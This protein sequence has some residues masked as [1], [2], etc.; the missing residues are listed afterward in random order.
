MRKETVEPRPLARVGLAGDP[1]RTAVGLQLQQLWK[2]VLGIDAVPPDADFFALGADSI[3]AMELATEMEKLFGRA[4]S[5]PELLEAATLDGMTRL[6]ES[7]ARERPI[8]LLVPLNK[9]GRRNPL[10][11]VHGLG[12]GVVQMRELAR[13]LD[14]DR[15]FYAFQARGLDGVARPLYRVEA[16]A[17]S[18]LDRMRQVRPA[19]P[20]LV[21]GYSMGG[22]VAYEMAR[23]LVAAGES[24]AALI[25][26]DAAAPLP[27]PWRDR[28]TS[29]FVHG[30]IALRRVRRQI[31]ARR[32]TKGHGRSMN[33]LM[34][35]NLA[36]VRRYRPSPY[37]GV[38]HVV[39]SRGADSGTDVDPRDRRLARRLEGLLVKQRDRWRQ[40]AGGGLEVEEVD[41]HHLELFRPP[42]LDGLLGALRAILARVEAR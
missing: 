28:L 15:P 23:R 8:P 42:A 4:V 25:V 30:R 2:Q 29:T 32:Q 18:Y 16:M 34:V 5:L 24:V 3:V 14:A 35:A 13:R 9:E 41:G 20:Y 10:F 37:A 26:I 1:G 6:I 17:E 27:L 40:L 7:R 31:A 12:G 19:G 38:I 39:S 36:A 22:V 33:R 11:V 21:A